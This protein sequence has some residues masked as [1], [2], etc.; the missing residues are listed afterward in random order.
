MQSLFAGNQQDRAAS[1]HHFI[2][3]S[4]WSIVEMKQRR[5]SKTQL[6]II[7]ESGCLTIKKSEL[8]NGVNL[9]AHLAIK[10]QKL[11]RYEKLFLVKEE[12]ELIGK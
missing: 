7:T 9:S 8:I 4:P 12:L 10:N 1:L 2:A 3:K 5:L 6:E 11:G